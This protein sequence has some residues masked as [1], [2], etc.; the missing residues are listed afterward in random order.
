MSEQP[1]AYTQE[2]PRPLPL[3]FT[4]EGVRRILL[5]RKGSAAIYALHTGGYEVVK[6]VVAKP[7]EMPNGVVVPWRELLPKAEDYG[8][9]GWYFMK[10]DYDRADQKYRGLAS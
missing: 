8:S 7:A 9:R 5:E 4:Y 6:I 1:S 3:Q 10:G 2:N